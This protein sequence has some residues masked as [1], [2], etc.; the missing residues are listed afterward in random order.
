MKR[1]ATQRHAV[2][3]ASCVSLFL[4]LAAC[5]SAPPLRTYLLTPPLES[6]VLTPVPALPT[7][8]ILIARVL[9]PDYL[10]TTDML[11][12]DGSHEVQA[13]TTGQWAER[14][15][16][17]L[18]RALAADLGARL[19][20]A[21]VV[22]DT[23][24]SAQRQVLVNVNALDLW[25]DGRCSL[26]ASW[27]IVDHDAPHAT[28]YGSGSFDSSP[29]GNTGV[30]GDVRLVDAVSRTVAKLAAAVALSFSNN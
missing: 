4:C 8:R 5:S 21:E 30:V 7:A 9:V 17:G 18:T 25:P 29:M 27:A 10:D 19:P 28:A 22:L 26:A 6:V 13:S 20:S 16:Q 15:S 12:R 14:L 2:V 23:S 1:D 3:C 11:V 24:S